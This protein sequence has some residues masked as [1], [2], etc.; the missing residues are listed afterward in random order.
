MPSAETPKPQL[1]LLFPDS[2]ADQDV[3]AVLAEFALPEDAIRVRKVE[4]GSFAALEWSMPTVFMATL[5]GLYL[6][7]LMT[8][9]AKDHYP[10]IVAGLKALAA[11]CRKMQIRWLNAE[12]IR[13]GLMPKYQQSAGFSIVVQTKSGQL[14]KLLFDQ[15]LSQAAWEDAIDAFLMLALLNQQK[16]PDDDITAAA[17]ALKTTH[18][19]MLYVVWS[20]EREQWE[21]EDDKSMMAKSRNS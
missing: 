18:N 20:R 8:E 4:R 10:K 5:S 9:A 2:Y 17:N 12:Q 14:V 3:A 6:K 1:S 21:F 16:A 15:A 19:G 13:H 7:A 11:R